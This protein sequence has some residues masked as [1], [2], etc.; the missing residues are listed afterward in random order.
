MDDKQ[1]QQNQSFF[2]ADI[3]Q[4]AGIG[5]IEMP[6]PP[7]KSKKMLYI[8]FSLG[9]LLILTIIVTVFLLLKED[10]QK[11]EPEQKLTFISADQAKPATKTLYDFFGTL[12]SSTFEL[13]DDFIHP[14]SYLKDL[15]FNK[16]LIENYSG[17]DVVWSQCSVDQQDSFESVELEYN[18]QKM[19]VI[20]IDVT[21]KT[22]ETVRKFEYDL[23]ETQDNNWAVFN[24]VPKAI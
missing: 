15:N 7:K 13:A 5:P 11:A 2:N 9:L 12:N 3:L 1:N 17:D 20:Y 10:S 14:D 18:A 6:L 21:C 16:E 24:I 23:R 19:K 8:L 22:A 4:Q